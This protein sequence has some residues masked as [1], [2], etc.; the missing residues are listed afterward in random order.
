MSIRENK[1]FAQPSGKKPAG[2]A[3]IV[4]TIAFDDLTDGGGA[5]GT[6]TLDESLPP[7]AVVQ[8]ARV[9]VQTAFD[10]TTT[11]VVG[12]SGDNDRYV[13]GALDVTSAGEVDA[14]EPSGVKAHGASQDVLVTVSESSDFSAITQGVVTVQLFYMV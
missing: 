11:L 4:Q 5:D 14:G 7:G 9:S 3:K 12:T 10:Q 6:L 1:D 13:S 8:N 2:L